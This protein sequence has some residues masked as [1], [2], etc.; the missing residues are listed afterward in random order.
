MSNSKDRELTLFPINTFIF[1]EDITNLPVP[2]TTNNQP[3]VAA[4]DIIRNP[5]II[6]LYTVGTVNTAVKSTC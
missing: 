5:P 1:T 3:L 2:D 6:I 4:D